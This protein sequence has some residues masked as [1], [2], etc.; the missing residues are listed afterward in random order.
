MPLS[1]V[2]P[3]LRDH[4]E[5]SELWAEELRRERM[6]FLRGGDLP[7]RAEKMVHFLNADKRAIVQ[8]ILTRLSN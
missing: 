5:L 8:E 2:H 1:A 3:G 6:G 7:S 4:L